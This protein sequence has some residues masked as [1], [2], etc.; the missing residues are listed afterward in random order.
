MK[1]LIVCS[2][3]TCRSPYAEFIF[4]RLVSE[5]DVLKTRIS[6]ASRRRR[7]FNQSRA[8]HPKNLRAPSGRRLHKEGTRRVQARLHS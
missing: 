1:I 5:S 8:M 7:F 3:N 6:K 2:S 4:K